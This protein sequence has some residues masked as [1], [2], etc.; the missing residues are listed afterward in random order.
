MSNVI[1][2]SVYW[3][4]PELAERLEIDKRLGFLAV[5]TQ[6]NF[7]VVT[8]PDKPRQTTIVGFSEG[9]PN[10]DENGVTHSVTEWDKLSPDVQNV[11]RQGKGVGARLYNV[12][13]ALGGVQT[14]PETVAAYAIALD[15]ADINDL[16]RRWHYTKMGQAMMIGRHAARLAEGLLLNPR[17]V[18]DRLHG[19]EGFKDYKAVIQPLPPRSDIRRALRGVGPNPILNAAFMLIRDS[20]AGIQR[21]GT[22][23]RPR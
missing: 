12:P 17:H 20:E 2:E 4:Y 5:D 10:E 9:L 21:V 8:H 22:Y 11:D 18:P 1:T 14:V 15:R 16:R 3:F 6:L 23:T 7:L 13:E 19:S